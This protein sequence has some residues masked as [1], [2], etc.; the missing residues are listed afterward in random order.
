MTPRTLTKR[1]ERIRP[2]YEPLPNRPNPQAE[3]ARAALRE[4]SAALLQNPPAPLPLYPL[5]APAPVVFEYRYDDGVQLWTDD[6]A[7]IGA[8]AKGE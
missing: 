1:A 2:D 6:P 3:Q 4:Y 5:E 7:S 8:G